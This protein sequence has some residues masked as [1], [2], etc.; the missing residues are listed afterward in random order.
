MRKD[1][2]PESV[3]HHDGHTKL[4]LEAGNSTVVEKQTVCIQDIRRK[5]EQVAAISIL[6]GRI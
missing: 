5:K 2:A 3:E 4:F 6:Q 1:V